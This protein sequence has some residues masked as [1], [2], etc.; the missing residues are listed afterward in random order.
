MQSITVIANF[1]LRLTKSDNLS[2]CNLPAKI[3]NALISQHCQKVDSTVYVA[4]INRKSD[5]YFDS[6]SIEMEKKHFGGYLPGNSKG[7]IQTPLLLLHLAGQGFESGRSWLT[8][9]MA[10]HMQMT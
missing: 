5:M 1:G 4:M 9:E 8:T 7:H 2:R 3:K 10:Q 6:V